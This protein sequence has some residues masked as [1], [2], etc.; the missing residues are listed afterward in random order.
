MEIKK[1][2]GTEL[3]KRREELAEAVVALQYSMQPDIWKPLGERGLEQSIRDAEYHLIYLAEAVEADE[4][5]LFTEYLSW[6]QSL[7]THLSLPSETLPITLECMQKTLCT[8]LKES[9]FQTVLPILAAGVESLSSRRVDASEFSLGGQ[10]GEEARR[11]LDAL[12]GG[13]HRTAARIV[14]DLVQN[15]MPI[16]QIYLKIF[17]PVQ[18]E[19]GRLWQTNRISVA[20]E[21]FCT[22]ATQTIMSQLYP[23]LFSGEKKSKKLVACCISG[24]LHEIGARMVADFMEMEG[25]DTYFMGANTPIESI[26]KTIGDQRADL[27]AVSATMTFHVSR[28]TDLIRQLR[29]SRLSDVPV[30]VGGYP[31][32]LSPELWRKVG[33]DGWAPDAESAVTVAEQVICR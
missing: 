32:N 21:H 14:M 16:K 25:W 31:F 8:A 13:D 1:T 20:Q 24:E 28:V 23:Y 10:L 7:F 17:Q 11:Y 12:L 26:L 6:V 30:L 4:P 29:E 18:R 22:A 19:V 15:G 9:L 3:R 33:A 2:A 5:A 27:L